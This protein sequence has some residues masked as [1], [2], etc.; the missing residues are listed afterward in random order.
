M[1]KLY[2]F[3]LAG[4]LAVGSQ[5]AAQTSA[6]LL[7]NPTFANS[8]EGWTN[9][10]KAGETTF[11][12]DGSVTVKAT[13]GGDNIVCQGV[14][15]QGGKNYIFGVEYKGGTEGQ[16][17]AFSGFWNWNGSNASWTGGAYTDM[18]Y[19]ADW[20]ATTNKY[21]PGANET[22]AVVLAANHEAE[23]NYRGVF[24]VEAPSIN[25]E[26]NGEAAPAQIMSGKKYTIA[27][28]VAGLTLTWSDGTT[29]TEAAEF[30]APA[31]GSTVTINAKYGNIVLDT[32]TYTVIASDAKVNLMG[33]WLA[34]QETNA[35]PKPQWYSYQGGTIYSDG[36]GNGWQIRNA[37]GE[38]NGTGEPK[39][40]LLRYNDKNSTWLYGY[41][42][43]AKA[44]YY[45]DYE[46]CAKRNEKEGTLHVWFSNSFEALGQSNDYQLT[47]EYPAEN[48]KAKFESYAAGDT[49]VIFS[50]PNAEGNAI[51]FSN[52]FSLYEGEQIPDAVVAERYTAAVADAKAI[53]DANAAVTGDVRT[54]LEAFMGKTAR[55][56]QLAVLGNPAGLKAA[57][58]AFNAI[59]KYNEALALNVEGREAVTIVNPNDNLEGWTCEGAAMEV[60]N[61]EGPTVADFV[62]TCKYFDH[63]SGGA[64]N[65]TMT[66]TV[67]VA[68]GEYRLAV[69]ARGSVPANE[70]RLFAGNATE[71]YASVDLTTCGSAG[72]AFGNGWNVYYVDFQAGGDLTIGVK[73]DMPAGG[74]VSCTGFSL[75]KIADATLAAGTVTF[76]ADADGTFT[77]VFTDVPEGARTYY[78]IE[79][80]AAEPEQLRAPAADAYQLVEDG[81]VTGVKAGSTFYYYSER[82][83]IKSAVTTVEVIGQG[84]AVIDA[85][86]TATAGESTYYNLNGVRVNPANLAPGVYVKIADGKA[87]KVIR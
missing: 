76:S 25:L 1:K 22:K 34:G 18:A 63:W 23:V 64:W 71:Q 8:G 30:T 78:A 27:C 3:M 69:L 74:W 38:L 6:N 66:Q 50:Y 67:N 82:N 24:V 32:K 53:L 59:V 62:P 80:A 60:K 26:L 44:G 7:V 39:T 36:N 68:A 84:S 11:N 17:H 28:T 73:I 9:T 42:V 47:T 54:A 45:Y 35:A 13:T 16:T 29:E 4:L 20:T 10:T 21:T 37:D 79:E 40:I 75:V 57:T 85:L 70:Y 65:S 2:T 41:K 48:Q 83:G 58:D 46:M 43:T 56:D 87:T 55:A 15:L 5:A 77:G 72:Q 81:T 31:V 51:A 61:G 14:E 52:F 86:D 12:A 49:Y 33:N 19:A